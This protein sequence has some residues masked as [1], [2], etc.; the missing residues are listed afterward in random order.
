MPIRFSLRS[1]AGSD[2]VA[3]GLADFLAALAGEIQLHLRAVQLHVAS[4]GASW[5]R[6]RRRRARRCCGRSGAAR[7]RS[8]GR[9][10]PRHSGGRSC[11]AADPLPAARGFSAARCRNA[12]AA[13]PSACRG[14]RSSR[15]GSGIAG[16]PRLSRPIAWRCAFGSSAMRTS[17]QAGGSTS[18]SIRARTFSVADDAAL[19]VEI[20]EAAAALA[21]ADAELLRLHIA[22]PVPL[23]AGGQ[24]FGH[25]RISL[26]P[27][28][29][30]RDA[31]SGATA[32][33][34]RPRLCHKAPA[35]RRGGSF[36]SGVSALSF[37][38]ALLEPSG[39]CAMD[40][41]APLKFGMGASPRRIEDGSLIR[42]EG[43][44]TTDVK[45]D[46][47]LTAYVLRSAAG[48]ARIAVGDLAAAR[49]A[50]GVHLVWVAADVSD[51]GLMPCMA[52]PAAKAP[53]EEPPYPVLCGDIVR[54]VGDAIAFIVADDLEQRQ[55][56]GR[57]DRGRLRPAA[58]HRRHR[59]RARAR[60]AAGLAGARQ[61]PRLRARDRR[62][63]GD[64]RRLRQ[65]RQ[66]GRDHASSTTA[67]SATTWSRGRSSPNT[68]RAAAATP[69]PS[70]RRAC[71][72]CA[73]PCARC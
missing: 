15:H 52:K 29:P 12:A 14:W 42:G 11:A 23:R 31:R 71:T 73:T 65:G 10:P 2:R 9:P 5:R 63:G 7:G 37:D 34:S 17:V 47:A 41:S 55:I 35:M 36:P 24:I 51:L 57:A 69:S 59:R 56:G 68:M 32:L 72:A 54:H 62:Q 40:Q 19:G 39:F 20:D 33:A 60:R 26:S 67:S 16:V 28:T 48:H 8:A 6:G 58:R 53:I 30:R 38:P 49:A 46:G 45:P 61:Q 25:W 50:P 4:S 21:A 1:R 3:D 13:P 66:G 27:L 70:A 64:R 18:A 44:Y 22:E 43:R